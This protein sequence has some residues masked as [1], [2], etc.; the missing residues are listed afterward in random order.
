[1]DQEYEK[2]CANCGTIFKHQSRNK[3]Y[4]SDE[5]AVKAQV[6]TTKKNK[7]KRRRKKQYSLNKEVLRALSASYKVSKKIADLFLEKKCVVESSEDLCEGELERH[8]KDLNPF[9]NDPRNLEYRCLKHHNQIHS[10]WEKKGLNYNMSERVVESL[11]SQRPVSAYV[12]SRMPIEY[13]LMIEGLGSEENMSALFAAL[14]GF[15]FKE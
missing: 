10:Y 12:V 8:H 5:C 3:R 13:V 9:N 1:M 4:C 15:I 14:S 11:K 7:Q 2:M 6:V